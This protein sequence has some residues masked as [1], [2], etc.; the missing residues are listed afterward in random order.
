MEV[1]EIIEVILCHLNQCFSSYFLVYLQKFAERKE[2]S[3][4]T[5]CQVA[6]LPETL[7]KDAVFK[8]H[9]AVEPSVAGNMQ[10]FRLRSPVFFSIK[11]Y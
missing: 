7:V 11:Y 8:N 1:G 4:A 6:M 10:G 5:Q 2:A 3:V 9:T